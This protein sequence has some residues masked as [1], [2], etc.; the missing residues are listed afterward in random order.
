MHLSSRE[1]VLIMLLAI[2][3]VVGV[4]SKFLISPQ[5]MLNT[6]LKAQLDGLV[7]DYAALSSKAATL[8]G[9]REQLD[10]SMERA[11]SVAEPFPD[12]RSAEALDAQL[13]AWLDD[14]GLDT[15][16]LTTTPLAAVEL[17]GFTPLGDQVSYPAGEALGLQGEIPLELSLVS[18]PFPC[19]QFA[20]T[21]RGTWEGILQ[22]MDTVKQQGR[23]YHLD[24]IAFEP[25]DP[26]ESA[27]SGRNDGGEE[28]GGEPAQLWQGNAAIRVY[29]VDKPDFDALFG[30]EDEGDD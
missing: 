24:S 3:L 1:K 10:A 25:W 5:K 15:V 6:Q 2:L 14:C 20:F 23:G 29:M 19:V 22:L 9:V 7:T 8:N 17:E 11:V 18:D 26:E 30:A 28:E 13:H 12:V 4:G 21:F 27:A 16:S